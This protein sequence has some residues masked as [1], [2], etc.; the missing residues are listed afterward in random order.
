MEKEPQMGNKEDTL[1]HQMQGKNE[2]NDRISDDT[3]TSMTDF[4]NTCENEADK[5]FSSQHSSE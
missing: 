1:K 5:H 3:M 4:W 2:F